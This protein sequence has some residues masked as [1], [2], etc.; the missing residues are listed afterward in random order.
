MSKVRYAC[1]RW[2]VHQK[3]IQKWKEGKMTIED[4]KS[5]GIKVIKPI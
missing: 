3:M 2:L 5:Y 1:K 4:L